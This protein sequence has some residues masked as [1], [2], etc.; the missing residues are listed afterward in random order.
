MN[1]RSIA[2]VSLVSLKS[3]FSRDTM[4][5]NFAQNALMFEDT[6]NKKEK[7]IKREII[8]RFYSC[9]FEFSSKLILLLYSSAIVEKGDINLENETFIVSSAHEKSTRTTMA[10]EKTQCQ[11]FWKFKTT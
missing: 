10:M 2:F 1:T 3:L 8:V 6:K 9:Y 4:E 7:N 5:E 11:H